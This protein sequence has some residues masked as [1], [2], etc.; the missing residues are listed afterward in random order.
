MG[1]IIELIIAA[2]IAGQL[3]KD[4]RNRKFDLFPNRIT[5]ILIFII[6]AIDDLIHFENHSTYTLFSGLILIIFNLLTTIFY[7]RKRKKG[8]FAIHII[9]TIIF[10]II[11]VGQLTDW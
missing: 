5:F 7:Y 8:Y 4:Y 3:F 1:F 6:A 9:N 2:S 11:I 10:S